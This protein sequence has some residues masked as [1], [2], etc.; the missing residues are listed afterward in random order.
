M[1]QKKTGKQSSGSSSKTST[2]NPSGAYVKRD[3]KTGHFVHVSKPVKVAPQNQVK[4]TTKRDAATGKFVAS[5]ESRS[6][7]VLASTVG[8]AV[9]GNILFPGIGGAIG[10]AIAGALLGGSDNKKGKR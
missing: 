2:K 5:G 7:K 3:S 10:G 4:P 9:I 8:G 6:S 1:N